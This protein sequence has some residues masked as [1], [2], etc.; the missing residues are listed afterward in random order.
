MQG[1]SP[2]F[3]LEVDFAS[4]LGPG[5]SRLSAA[6]FVVRVGVYASGPV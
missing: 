6:E 5:S 1:G 2:A 3:D 4:G